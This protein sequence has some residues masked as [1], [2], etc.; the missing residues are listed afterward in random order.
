VKSYGGVEQGHALRESAEQLAG[1]GSWEWALE[2]DELVWSDNLF[3]I[4]G[5]DPNEFEPTLEFMIEHTHPQDRDSV[6]QDIERAREGEE[7]TSVEF[8][9]VRWDRAIRHLR[10]T[11]TQVEAQPRRLT[12]Y[13]Q[14]VTESRRAER[15]IQT[16]IAVAEAL[17]EWESLERSGKR[18]LQALGEAME[19]VTGT[20]WLPQGDSLIARVWWQAASVDAPELELAVRARRIPSGC[21]LPGRVWATGAAATRDPVADDPSFEVSHAMPMDGPRGGVGFPALKEEEVLAV[22]TFDSREEFPSTDHLLRSLTGIGRELGHF[23]DRRRGE[24]VPTTLTPREI[25]VLQLASLGH[26]APSIAKE[27]IVSRDTVK[28][29]LRHVYSKLGVNDRATA[30][31]QALRLGLIE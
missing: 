2:S 22:L 16:H 30:V 24:L 15:A 5:L 28:T 23:L 25:E 12:G 7:I 1:M 29:H 20:I 26:S 18:L 8:R 9:I 10:S 31:A 4:Y 27:L 13:I 6:I 19:F 11:V 21:G 3:R 17:G 14:D